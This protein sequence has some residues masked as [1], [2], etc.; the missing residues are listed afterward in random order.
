M[1]LGKR[2]SALSDLI[3]QATEGS[4]SPDAPPN[5]AQGSTPASRATVVPII[6]V[7]QAQS[8]YA[9]GQ[10]LTETFFPGSSLRSS[11]MPKSL[12]HH[13]P[14]THGNGA[15][16]LGSYRPGAHWT[17]G[18]ASQVG[19]KAK[20]GAALAGGTSRVACKRRACSAAR[21]YEKRTPMYHVM[22]TGMYI[23]RT[24]TAVCSAAG[25]RAAERLVASHPLNHP[26]PPA[27][28]A[29]RPPPLALLPS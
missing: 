22:H 28:H 16:L 8:T 24:E 1:S 6:G 2:S 23:C 15:G 21:R 11:F 4:S 17:P 13:G 18:D 3:R 12:T 10:D 29:L 9:A 25:R 27:L 5:S 14:G 7:G 26:P 20:L 19:C